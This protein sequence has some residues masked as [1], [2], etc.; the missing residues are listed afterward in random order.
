MLG[1]CEVDKFD[2]KC[3]ISVLI[4]DLDS[5]EAYCGGGFIPTGMSGWMMKVNILVKCPVPSWNTPLANSTTTV[6]G[7]QILTVDFEQGLG[8]GVKSLGARLTQKVPSNTLKF[9]MSSG[10]SGKATSSELKN[11]S[12]YFAKVFDSSG[13]NLIELAGALQMDDSLIA[14]NQ[15][16]IDFVINRPHKFLFQRTENLLAYSPEMGDGADFSSSGCAL[17]QVQR[18]VAPV[19]DKIGLSSEKHKLG[20]E[21]AVCFVQPYYILVD[22]HNTIIT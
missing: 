9:D 22:H 6:S 1:P 15:S 19:L 21:E 2:G 16:F 11:D 18:L 5:L 14:S 3:W 4:D 7:Y 17:V 10:V 13:R 12:G 8:G 20:L